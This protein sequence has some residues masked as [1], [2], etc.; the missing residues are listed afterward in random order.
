MLKIIFQK[1]TFVYLNMNPVWIKQSR[2]P[3]T[4]LQV[5]P[6]EAPLGDLSLLPVELTV[7]P[8]VVW[9]DE[10]SVVAAPVEVS[11]REVIVAELG[12]VEDDASEFCPVVAVIPVVEAMIWLVGSAA[13]VLLDVVVPENG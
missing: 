7:G 5:I 8:A 2:N 4:I 10:R 1:K 13:E 3:V 6:G 11:V 12:T 9:A